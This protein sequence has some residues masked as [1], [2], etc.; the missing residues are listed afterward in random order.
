MK[1]IVK[2]KKERRY[3]IKLTLTLALNLRYGGILAYLT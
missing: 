1:V 2:Y 3:Q